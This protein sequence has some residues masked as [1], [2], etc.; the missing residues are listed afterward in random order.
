MTTPLRVTVEVTEDGGM[1]LPAEIR[2]ALGLT[3]AGQVILDQ[4]EDGIR[5]T[6]KDQIVKRVRALA[7]LY[8]R[9]SGSLAD[10]LIA[11]R[12]AE[13]AREEAED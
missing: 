13:V 8:L 12:R 2:S 6:T 3:G 11:D 9:G 4:D 5:I 1:T 7:A 10:E